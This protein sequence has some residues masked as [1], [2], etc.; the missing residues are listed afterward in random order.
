MPK[1]TTKISGFPNVAIWLFTL[2][3][4]LKVYRMVI[5]IP[6]LLQLRDFYLHLLGVPDNEMQTISWQEIVQRIMALRDQNPRTTDKI[7]PTNRKWIGSQSKERLDAHDIA[8]RLMRKENYLIA[9]FNKEILDMTLPIP[10]LR[11]RQLF[12]RTLLWNLDWCIMDF[13]FNEQGQVRQLVLKDSHRRQLSDALRSRFLFA[14][15]M[16]V[17]FAPAIIMYLSVVYFFTYFNVRHPSAWLPL[18]L[19]IQ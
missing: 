15:L 14:G 8:N 5:G 10:F 12:S 18:L 4:I 2:Y 13:V 6:R 3:S 16:N 19:T 11:G 7:S 9:M 1:C 17:L